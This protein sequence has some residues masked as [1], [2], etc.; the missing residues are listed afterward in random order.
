MRVSRIF[1]SLAPL[2]S[3]VSADVVL[4]SSD[5]FVIPQKYAG[6]QAAV[7]NFINRDAD[8]SKRDSVSTLEG[9]INSVVNSGII[10]DVIDEIAGSETQ[11]DNLA[12]AT[13][14]ILGGNSSALTSLLNGYNIS[15]N[16]SALTQSVNESGIVPSTAKA[17]LMNETNREF[18]AKKVGTLLV[19][20]VWISQLLIDLGHNG[21]LTFDHI[22]HLIKTVTSKANGTTVITN[23]DPNSKAVVFG[24]R[25]DDDNSGSAQAFFNNLV[26]QVVGS[27]IVSQSANDF[28]VAL[29]RTG[30]VA[31]LTMKLMDLPSVITLVRTLSPKIYASGVLDKYDLDGGYTKLKKENVLSDGLQWILTQPKYSPP[32]G[33]LLKYLDQNGYYQQIQNNLYGPHGDSMTLK[34]GTL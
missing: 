19:T 17:L 22:A 14:A 18:V 6:V 12:N 11:M 28:L 1:A 27:N 2:L 3:L 25:A 20:Q 34:K 32:L 23:S 29:N 10:T 26:G 13:I 33:L 8:L 5:Q 16:V 31:P 30:V 7:D 9:V 4:P 21:K 15:L 24:K